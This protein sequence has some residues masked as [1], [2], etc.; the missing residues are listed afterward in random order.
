[1]V[2][3]QRARARP[4][5][6]GLPGR[7]AGPVVPPLRLR[8]RPARHRDPPAG[9]RAARLASHHVAGDDPSLPVRRVR[10]RVAPRHQRRGRTTGEAVPP[11][12][13]VGAGRHRRPASDR[14]PGRRGSRRVVEHRQRR[15]PGRGPP[16]PDRRSAPLRRRAGHRRRRARLAAHPP[17]R[18]VRH[19]D[20]RPH[21]DPRRHRPGPAAGHG[22]GPL[23][24]GVQDLARRPP[25][26]LARRRRG[27]CD[28]RVHRLQDRHHRGA[29]RRGRG[30]GPL[31][32]RPPRRRRARPVPA[33][34][35]AGP[36]RPPRPQGR[37][38]LPRPGGPCTPAPTC[39][40]TSRRT[41]SKHCSQ[42]T[43]TSRS[44]RPGASTSG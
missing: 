28:G 3:G 23:Q 14:R 25:P 32:R 12:A 8:G 16:G 33:P 13:A 1:M 29:A 31:P 35:P 18:Q 5:G 11:R 39:S 9:A 15:R 24:A 34:G 44:R 2:T 22:R 42:P 40:P 36:A 26:G 6:A 27:R 10:A 41:G 37:P 7:P 38:A 30:D 19:R 43:P 4:G 20:H 21:P 17:R